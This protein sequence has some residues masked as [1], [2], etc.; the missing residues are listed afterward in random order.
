MLWFDD[1]ISIYRKDPVSWQKS[2]IY[3]YIDADIQVNSQKF[4]WWQNSNNSEMSD[5]FI[6]IKKEYKNLKIWDIIEFEDAFWDSVKVKIVSR[7]YVD[8][9]C[10]EPFIEIL[11]KLK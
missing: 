7:D 6:F 3:T 1:K 8:F 11:C 9:E 4:L 2:Y 10:Y 5:Y